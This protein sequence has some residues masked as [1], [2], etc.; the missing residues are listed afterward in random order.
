MTVVGRHDLEPDYAAGIAAQIEHEG[1]G[2]RVSILGPKR[3]SEMPDIYQTHDL[4]VMP[5]FYEPFGIV[6]LE[7]MGAGL[8]V[9]ASHA[10]AGPEL[11]SPGKNGFLVRPESAVDVAQRRSK[12]YLGIAPG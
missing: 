12:R 2:E 4:F 10:G 5:S 6:Y 7:A 8:P 3:Y 1:L 11:I 9:I